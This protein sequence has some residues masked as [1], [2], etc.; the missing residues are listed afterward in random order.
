MIKAIAYA[1]VKTDKVDAR[2]LADLDRT[3]MIPKAYIPNERTR[4]VRDR[5]CCRQ[6]FVRERTMHKNK[7]KA[8]LAKLWLDTKASP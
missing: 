7:I 6:S 3:V 4:D 8:D 1:K 5:V 2:M